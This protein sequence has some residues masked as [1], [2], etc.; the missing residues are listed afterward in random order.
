MKVSFGDP[1]SL[2]SLS[3]AEG[4]LLGPTPIVTFG[5]M[6]ANKKEELYS[7]QLG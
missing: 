4:S 5:T 1:D 6:V 2:I 3:P 7:L